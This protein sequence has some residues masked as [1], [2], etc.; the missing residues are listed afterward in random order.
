MEDLEKASETA[1]HE[2]GR[3]RATVD[4]LQTELKEYRKRLSMNVSGAGYSPPQSATR[5]YSNNSNGNDFSFA[6]PKF[7]DLP[8]S[9]MNN[10]SMAKTTSPTQ[11]SPSTATATNSNLRRESS[12]STKAA[13]PTG[14]NNTATSQLTS[15]PTQTSLNGVSS[16]AYDELNGL[17]SP[18]ILASASRSTSADYLSHNGS[19][20]SLPNGANQKSSFV[21]QNGQSQTPAPRQ[22]STT[23]IGSPASSM[24][25]ALDSSCGTTPESSGES[26]DT[27]KG[28][29]SNLNTI[30]EEGRAQ[31]GNGGKIF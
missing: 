21:K 5:G 20:G 26:P 4:K 24:S 1:N 15:S 8:G 22:Q 27:R 7:G 2:N 17:F 14:V 30:N 3:L 31:K 19:N 13:S 10:G 18:T 11:S 9:F 23:S 16:N 29:E 25:H 28:S 6:F 12:T